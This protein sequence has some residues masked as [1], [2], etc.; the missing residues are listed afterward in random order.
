MKRLVWI[1]TLLLAGAVNAQPSDLDSMTDK[2]IA[3]L[4]EHGISELPMLQLLQRLA[5]GNAAYMQRIV[6]SLESTLYDLRYYNDWPSGEMNEKLQDAIR[7]FQGDINREQTGTLLYGEFVELTRRHD[8]TQ[9]TPVE[10]TV[11]NKFSSGGGHALAEGTWIIADSTKPDI[12][13]TSKIE[14]WKDKGVCREA[15]ARVSGLSNRLYV[16]TFEMTITKWT[17]TEI[18]AEDD[19]GKCDSYTLTLNL[20]SKEATKL[21]N[22]KDVESCHHEGEEPHV[23]NLVEGFEVSWKAQNALLASGKDA[24]NKGYSEALSLLE[25]KY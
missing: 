7:S 4:S 24:R 3:M 20:T 5:K 17:E 6:I 2:D 8:F 13:Q 19:S 12:M 10:L 16:D 18:V 21:E 15:L 11:Y 1:F 14:C 25:Q 22:P 23:L 9:P